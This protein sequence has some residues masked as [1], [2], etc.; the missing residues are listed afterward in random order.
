VVFL[1]YRDD[2]NVRN[3]NLIVMQFNPFH[4]MAIDMIRSFNWVDEFMLEGEYIYRGQLIRFCF[5]LKD[6]RYRVHSNVWMQLLSSSSGDGINEVFDMVSTKEF[7]FDC[8]AVNFKKFYDNETFIEPVII[9]PIMTRGSSPFPYS[10]IGPFNEM[11]KRGFSFHYSSPCFRSTFEVKT[12]SK[13]ERYVDITQEVTNVTL[14][15]F[16]YRGDKHFIEDRMARSYGY[17]IKIKRKI[18]T[19]EELSEIKEKKKKILISKRKRNFILKYLEKKKKKI[20]M[21]IVSFSIL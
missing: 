10:I 11:I 17:F 6:K 19:K 14:H 5:S 3:L 7:P 8:A 2:V 18:K 16:D 1:P 21:K 15:S 9:E 20:M 12:T 4:P 13:M